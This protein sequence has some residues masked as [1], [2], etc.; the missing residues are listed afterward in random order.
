M[1]SEPFQL[2]LADGVLHGH[3]EGDGSLPALL[4][5]GGPAVP[6]YTEGCALELS[7]FFST[8]RYT[9]RGTPPSSVVPPYSI[10]A[11]VADAL[12]VLDAFELERAWAIGHS[13]GGHLALHL[14]VAHPE[15]LQGIVCVDPLGADGAILA[16][17]DANLRRSLTEEQIARV[18][19][20][21]AARRAGTA[22]ESDLVERYGLL[23]PLYFAR[24]ETATPAP[25]RVGVHCSTDTNRSIS[26]HFERGTLV[27]GLRDVRL[28]ALFVHGLEDPLPPRASTDTAALIE[29]AV[30]ATIPDCGHFPW[31]ERPGELGRAVE[32]FLAAR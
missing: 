7:P 32:R 2:P 15:R 4:L 6:D 17:L 24:P 26:E 3:A 18:E 23:W 10:E 30:V 11:H 19:E 22:N 1:R 20:I 9:Q 12:A 5:H 27:E 28:P 25:A 29:G 31:W 21:E 8:I 16:E 14:A 13:F